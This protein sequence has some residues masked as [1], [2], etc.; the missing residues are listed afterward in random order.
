[1]KKTI[2]NVNG[3]SLVITSVGGKLL[4]KFAKSGAMSI[5]DK[6]KAAAAKA[7]ASGGTSAPTTTP[8]VTT[9]NSSS[10]KANAKSGVTSK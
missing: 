6:I 7:S 3:K 8:E 10:I 5:A 1:M 2:A 9:V 4:G